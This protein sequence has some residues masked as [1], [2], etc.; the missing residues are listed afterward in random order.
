MR[1]LILLTLLLQSLS[2]PEKLA[3][4][5]AIDLD[6]TV[7]S[8]F[9]DL[10]NEDDAIN[11]VSNVTQVVKTYSSLRRYQRALG[12]LSVVKQA[13]P[14]PYY[15][16]KI[17]GLESKVLSCFSDY[18]EAV[19]VLHN[20]RDNLLKYLGKLGREELG[21]YFD[22]WEGIYGFTSQLITWYA[23]TGGLESVDRLSHWMVENGP[24][25]TKFQLP[26]QYIPELPMN[27]WPRDAPFDEVQGIVE[28]GLGIFREEWKTETVQEEL[29]Y[30]HDP[31]CLLGII[32][33]IDLSLQYFKTIDVITDENKI[34]CNI[35]P[36]QIIIEVDADGNEVET[37]LEPPEISPICRILNEINDL[38]RV[39]KMTYNTI[40]SYGKTLGHFGESNA[41]IDN[42]EIILFDDSFW[43]ILENVCDSPVSF[44]RIDVH[45]PQFREM[46]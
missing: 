38:H 42:D 24:Y 14:P 3:L 31:D 16:Y 18:N 19:F 26:I 6:S 46:K 25:R 2:I 41:L 33:D 43:T 35:P 1:I 7:R 44:I 23:N 36:P 13:L 22:V 8:S 39:K 45:H 5:N 4:S 30:S 28:R 20:A 17:A 11:I 37:T 15:A 10:R 32:P 27:P 34:H 12:H 21:E 9:L 29:S 40:S